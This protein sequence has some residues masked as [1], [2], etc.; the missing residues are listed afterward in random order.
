MFCTRCGSGLR[1]NDKFCSQCGVQ[2]GALHS[3]LPGREP[4][5][6]LTRL[7]NEKKIAGVCAGFARYFD[8]DVTLMRLLWLLVALIT[9]VGFVVYLVA[10][11]A[12]PAENG[13]QSLSIVPAGARSLRPL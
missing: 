10:W 1:E 2:L 9:G 7:I 4:G 3:P 6:P 11:M 13:S 8:V 12:M 5:H